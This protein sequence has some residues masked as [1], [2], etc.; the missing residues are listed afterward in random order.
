[1]QAWQ[2]MARSLASN[3]VVV[4]TGEP[5]KKKTIG[6]GF[7]VFVT[8]E[9]ADGE[10]ENPR[11]EMNSRIVASMLTDRPVVRSEAS[12]CETH[13]PL[14]VVIMGGHLKYEQLSAK[15]A[16]QAELLLPMSFAEVH[17]GYRLNR[18]IIETL[19]AKHRQLIESSGVWRKVVDYPQHNRS[20]LMLT[21]KDA[22]SVSGSVAGRLFDYHKPILR[23]R[24]TEK[25]L[26]AEALK[27][28]TDKELAVKLNLSLPTV[29]KRW[30][31]VFDRIAEARPDLLPD[32]GPRE[33]QENRGPQ[34]RH[35]IMA[36]VRAHPEEVRPY[37]WRMSV[38]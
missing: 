34:K 27:G 22:F 33:S 23:L 29:K 10:L 31:S 4:E 18:V 3:S 26:L 15:E 1:M 14:D 7:S 9:F 25:Q 30:A 11:P 17:V 35:R 6:F 37:R 13:E 16:I 19:T 5:M 36:Y 2:K 21:S 28:G 12:L 38:A 8:R 20:L 32:G 24:D